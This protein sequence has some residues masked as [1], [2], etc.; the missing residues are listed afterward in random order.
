MT[1]NILAGVFMVFMTFCT[2]GCGS[3][4]V[5]DNDEAPYSI[6]YTVNKYY[7]GY[8]W[9]CKELSDG[10]YKV[11]IKGG[12]VFV[13]KPVYDDPIGRVYAALISYDGNGDPMPSE[14]AVDYLGDYPV[15]LQYI[16]EI[17]SISRILSWSVNADNLT[18][19][20]WDSQVVYN[21]KTGEYSQFFS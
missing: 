20:L 18:L 3:V 15:L 17:D 13:L 16:E 4:D 1:R 5:D 6:E 12:P 8:G 10:N 19:G 21:I 14:M 9:G 11:T 2:I 7:A